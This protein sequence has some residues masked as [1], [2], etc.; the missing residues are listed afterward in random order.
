MSNVKL[1]STRLP[2]GRDF[3]IV[4]EPGTSLIPKFTTES[5]KKLPLQ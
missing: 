3:G 1:G 4:P 2:A 5:N